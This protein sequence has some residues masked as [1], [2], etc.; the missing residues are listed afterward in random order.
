NVNASNATIQMTGGT[1]E[2]TGQLSN[3]ANGLISGRGV[4]RGSTA[5]ASGTGLNNSGAVAFSAGYSDAYGKVN[6]LARGQIVTA[7]GG[8]P[9][10]FRN[11]ERM[12]VRIGGSGQAFGS[13]SFIAYP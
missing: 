2:F 8:S 5:N 11:Q 3:L 10:G 13:N 4:L 12:R 1:I 9:C 7:G 6:N